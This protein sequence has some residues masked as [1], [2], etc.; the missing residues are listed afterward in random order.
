MLRILIN[1]LF[2]SFTVLLG[3][4]SLVFFIFNL[5]PADPARQIAG[6]NDSEEVLAAIRKN[7]GLDLP[8]GTRYLLY[9][10]D[11]SP[12]SIHNKIDH[13]SPSFLSDEKYSYFKLFN[14]SESALVLK[15]PYLRRSYKSNRPVAE[16]IVSSLPGTVILAV[17]AMS[18]ALI[19]GI[20]L[21][22][23]TA[24]RKGKPE[25]HL[26]LFISALGMSL[27]SFFMAI[28]VAWLGGLVWFEQIY[29]PLMP[30][31]FMILVL[32]LY[33]FKSKNLSP[34]IE[35]KWT[36]YAIIGF[37]LG[38]LYCLLPL[39]L[40]V[41][42]HKFM[43]WADNLIYLPGTGL[44][45]T[46][47]LYDIDPWIGV[48]L[49]PEN[50]ILPALT[51]GIRPLSVI[52]QLT[53]NSLLEVLDSDFVRTAKAKGLSPFRVIVIHALRNAL[54]PVVTAVSGW[55]AS[56]LAGAVFVE[57][58]FGWKGL[59][60]EVFS[61]LEKEDLPVVMGAVLIIAC[62]FVLINLLVDIIYTWLDPRV[63]LNA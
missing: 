48:Y 35:K 20:A 2:Y 51:L 40:P 25:D 30:F 9:L 11:L 1:K 37:T 31:V 6:Q 61:A 56:L 47:S 26:S 28:L 4:V 19:F 52:V 12:I 18:F 41:S 53:R 58:V 39:L 23:F 43:P 38:L 14:F 36:K 59:G 24:L 32:I 16:I 15:F 54:N 44:P 46:G 8:I 42:I 13:E 55:F 34:A 63:R 27:P 60:L 22:I 50:L 7:L 21:G 57:F 5:S 10:N 33:W 29:F 17:S 45:M 3:V 49:K 62:T